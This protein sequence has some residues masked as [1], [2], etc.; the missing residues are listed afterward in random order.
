MVV[1]VFTA[2]S[3]EYKYMG[4]ACGRLIAGDKTIGDPKAEDIANAEVAAVLTAIRWVL[5]L[6]HRPAHLTVHTDSL[7]TAGAV[8]GHAQ[9]KT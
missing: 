9:R 7:L 1:L 6:K 5:Q 8:E 4:T 3:K 2:R